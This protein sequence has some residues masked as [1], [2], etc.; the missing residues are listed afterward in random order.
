MKLIINESNISKQHF[1]DEN[2]SLNLQI[3]MLQ[4]KLDDHN[5]FM[6]AVISNT[7]KILKLYDPIYSNLSCLSWLE[8]LQSPLMLIWGHSIWMNWFNQH[9]D[10]KSKD[11]IVFCEE[12]KIETK[13]KEL[14]E[15]KVI[16]VFWEKFSTSKKFINDILNLAVQFSQNVK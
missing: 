14:M 4:K 16:E 12:C 5:S 8:F 3:K 11:S 6:E 7:K 13:N 15:S 9:S 1:I 10:P 2:N